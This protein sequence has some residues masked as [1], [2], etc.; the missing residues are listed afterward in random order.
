MF[1]NYSFN[2]FSTEKFPID[3]SQSNKSLSVSTGLAK[4]LWYWKDGEVV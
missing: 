2:Y 3:M 4:G 1:P